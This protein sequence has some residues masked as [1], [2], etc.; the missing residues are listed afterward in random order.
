MIT[1]PEA[2]NTIIRRSRYLR[3]AISKDLINYSSLARYIKPELEEILK[4]PV[5]ES[6][7]LMAIQRLSKDYKPN[8]A[9]ESIFT[10]SIS[11]S[12]KSNLS[13]VEISF[14][15]LPS[16]TDFLMAT[17]DSK[18]AIVLAKK[19]DSLGLASKN[20]IENVS[21]ISIDLPKGALENSGSY[22][23]FLKSFAWEGVNVLSSF[24]TLDTFTIVVRDQDLKEAIGILQSLSNK[25]IS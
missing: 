20:V 5:S 17:I 9:D 11:F 1:V 2:T 6:S 10:D 13:L 22:Y 12:T 4:K 23:F 24:S 19:G 15:D 25:L 18:T 7:I 3:E 8:Y 21:A 16:G 14:S